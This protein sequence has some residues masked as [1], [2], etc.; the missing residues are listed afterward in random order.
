MCAVLH[1]ISRLAVVLEKRVP[2]PKLQQL[3]RV[4]LLGGE[5]D[6]VLFERVLLDV[7]DLLVVVFRP[8]EIFVA[9][10]D[11][12][13]DGWDPPLSI[14]ICP[15]YGGPLRPLEQ[16]LPNRQCQNEKKTTEMK[17]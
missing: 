17:K 14:V 4:A 13:K 1:P 7:E 12:S 6:V 10:L 16:R 15:V 3:V 8:V 9:L 5:E 11:E 2:G